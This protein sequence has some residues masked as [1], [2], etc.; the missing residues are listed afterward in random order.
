MESVPGEGPAL[1][2]QAGGPEPTGLGRSVGH[3]DGQTRLLTAGGAFLYYRDH[4]AQRPLSSA[5]GEDAGG[6]RSVSEG[7]GGLSSPG[8]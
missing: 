2:G 5:C 7:R 6:G 3:A 1:R 4:N 8:E